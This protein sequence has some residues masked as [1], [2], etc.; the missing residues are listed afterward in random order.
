M[1]DPAIVSMVRANDVTILADKDHNDPAIMD[2]VRQQLSALSAQGL[3]HLYVEQDASEITLRELTQADTPLGRMTA[4]AERLGIRVHF[5]DDRSE[6]RAL[7]AR[8]PEAAAYAESVGDY[9]LFDRDALI[10]GAPNTEDMRAY[11]A[12]RDETSGSQQRNASIIRNIDQ[13]LDAA[14]GEKAMV[15]IGAW[16]VEQR[17]DIDEGLRREGHQT[18]VIEIKSDDTLVVGRG[19]DVP[20]FIAR[21]ET[22]QAITYKANPSHI[23]L[24]RIT[25]G[26][27]LPWRNQEPVVDIQTGTHVSPSSPQGAT[28]TGEGPSIPM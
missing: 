25:E 5:F 1:N 15:V 20:D 16:H 7:T 4:E 10:A 2:H 8:Y 18:G 19:P 13:G 14:P 26:L 27:E 22:G 12:G 24:Q 28:R 17:N 3:Q 11:I 23:S 21:T 6:E 9:Y